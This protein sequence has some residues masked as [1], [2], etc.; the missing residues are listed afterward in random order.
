M[1]RD[2]AEKNSVMLRDCR[3]SGVWNQPETWQDDLYVLSL[4]KKPERPTGLQCMSVQEGAQP[5]GKW[6]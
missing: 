2:P 1:E 6:G 4:R 3:R 5:R